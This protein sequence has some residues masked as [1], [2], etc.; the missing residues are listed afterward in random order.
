MSAVL[1]PLF[2]FFDVQAIPF[3]LTNKLKEW[4][5]HWNEYIVPQDKCIRSHLNE[6]YFKLPSTPPGQ[7]E[8]TTGHI[9]VYEQSSQAF[10]DELRAAFNYVPE[11]KDQ[12]ELMAY[13]QKTI[14]DFLS[15]LAY[16]TQNSTNLFVQKA[17]AKAYEKHSQH[18]AKLGIH[19]NPEPE[20]TTTYSAAS[21]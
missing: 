1:F 20:Y 9:F 10:I 7:L 18:F 15:D 11:G 12:E 16:Y 17:A 19:F 21:L 3:S 5:T 13:Y 2:T 8:C 14:I 6:A 4:D